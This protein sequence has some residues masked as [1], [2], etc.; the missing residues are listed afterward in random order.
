M[1]TRRRGPLWIISR[2]RSGTRARARVRR[3][4][5]SF[6]TAEATGIIP[7]RWIRIKRAPPTPLP[8]ALLYIH[9]ISRAVRKETDLPSV[10]GLIEVVQNNPLQL[11]LPPQWFDEDTQYVNRGDRRRSG[12][13][14]RSSG[15]EPPS[16]ILTARLTAAWSLNRCTECSVILRASVD[17]STKTATIDSLKDIKAH[18]LPVSTFQR[19]FGIC[20]RYGRERRQL[21]VPADFF[22]SAF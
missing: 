4:R 20:Q 14:S 12:N 2:P 9:G 7:A 16:A 18:N 13:S 8:T 1:W 3:S 21:R 11:R 5:F 19:V 10:P 6:L 17:G 15:P 22:L